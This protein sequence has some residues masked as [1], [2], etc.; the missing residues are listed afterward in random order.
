MK[1][2][3]ITAISKTGESV[4]WLCEFETEYRALEWIRSMAHLGYKSFNYER[5]QA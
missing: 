1:A 3:N 2:Y 4:W 5:V